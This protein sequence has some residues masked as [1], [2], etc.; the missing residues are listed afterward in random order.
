MPDPLPNRGL[1][2]TLAYLWALAVIPLFVSE[3]AEV[4][5]HA[6]NGITLAL[7]ELLL[8]SAYL[9]LT[10]AASLVTLGLGFLLVLA[11]PFAWIAVVGLHAIAIIKGLNGARL[12]VPGV[13]DVADRF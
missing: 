5:W 7:A 6:R 8:V 10:A 3:D 9:A 12:R 13:S 4:K 1:M 11:V 2:I